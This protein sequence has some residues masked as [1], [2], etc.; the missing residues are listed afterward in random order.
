MA[1]RF[2]NFFNQPVIDRIDRV[3]RPQP[4][5]AAPA[6]VVPAA[7]KPVPDPASQIQLK[8]T[9]QQMARAGAELPPLGE[10][11]FQAY[12]QNDEDGILLFLFAVIGT[13]N[14]KCVE[15]SAGNGKECNTA[16]LIINHGWTGLLVDGN[17]DAVREGQEFYRTHRST[18]I[19]PP[20]FVCEWIKRDNVNDILARN[21]FTGE[22]DLLSIDVDGVDYWI[23]ETID[24]IDPRVVVVEYQNIIGPNLALTVPYADD[25]D[26]YK[27]P[28]TKGF[29]NYCGASLAAFVKL[30][31]RK[32]YRLAGCGR[33]GCN[34]FF[35]RNGLGEGQIP[36]VEASA[37][38]D[39]PLSVWGMKERFPVV[40][41]L[42][43]V[44]IE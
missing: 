41:D 33:N 8:L 4:L 32:G 24:V 18:Y 23:W 27:Y 43:W 31:A 25:F 11:G 20:A 13:V 26:A 40:K 12:S 30:A 16:N 34:A 9:Y 21:G 14:R 22:V 44:V 3:S 17:A 19:C 10:V 6:A 39:Q 35:I 2:R 28:T 29:P 7:Q 36:A 15:I 38:F 42:P 5:L 1:H 37:C